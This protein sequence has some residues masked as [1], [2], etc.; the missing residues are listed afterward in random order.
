MAE[1]TVTPPARV[2]EAARRGL[3]LREAQTPSNR[4]GTRIG[5]TRANQ[6]ARR[7]PVSL[8][9]LQRMASF[10]ARHEVDKQGEGW[11][12]DSPGYQ[13]WLLWGGDPGRTWA[14]RQIARLTRKPNAS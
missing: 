14:A 3:E 7:D 1:R 12:V 10:F 13:A 9:T 11:G 8:S 4:G 2:A 6:L 5:L